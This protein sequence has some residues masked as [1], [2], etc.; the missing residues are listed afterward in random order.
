LPGVRAERL[1]QARGEPDLRGL[2]RDDGAR[3][4]TAAGPPAGLGTPEASRI[5]PDASPGPA[6][7]SVVAGALG[8][9]VGRPDAWPNAVPARRRPWLPARPRPTGGVRCPRVPPGRL[10]RAT[11]PRPGRA[12]SPAP[13]RGQRNWRD[14]RGG[15]GARARSGAG[16]RSGPATPA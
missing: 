1:G 14:Q 15:S 16:T 6:E 4:V 7:G 2:R 13:P 9:R 8:L 10:A 11:E 5:D 12:S 3:Q